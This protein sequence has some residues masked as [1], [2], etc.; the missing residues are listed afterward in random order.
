MF[1]AKGLEKS[2][3]EASRCSRGKSRWFDEV[4]VSGGFQVDSCEY[5]RLFRTNGFS[6]HSALRASLIFTPG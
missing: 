2:R 1:F 6:D 5:L 3:P 4:F